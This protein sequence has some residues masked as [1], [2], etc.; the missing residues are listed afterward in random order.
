[1]SNCQDIAQV[2][3]SLAA[4][5]RQP[6]WTRQGNRS[7]GSQGLSQPPA[8][9]RAAPAPGIG[10][11][12]GHRDGQRPSWDILSHEWKLGSSPVRVLSVR[13]SP[14]TA[15]LRNLLMSW[16][17]DQQCP[18]PGPGMASTHLELKAGK[19]TAYLQQGPMDPGWAEMGLPDPRMWVWGF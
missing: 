13:H 3:C 1:M 18:R 16:S 17:R 14:G 11:L 19:P 9:S 8:R 7:G 4:G 12:P 15:R 10:H 2:S 6:R 5:R